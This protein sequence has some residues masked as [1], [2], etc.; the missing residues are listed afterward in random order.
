MRGQGV[1]GA[2]T[3]V[4]LAI[5]HSLDE[6][7]VALLV[8]TAEDRANMSEEDLDWYVPILVQANREELTIP[9]RD[10]EFR[11]NVRGVSGAPDGP[12]FCDHCLLVRILL[13]DECTGF[14]Q[15]EP[16]EPRG[17]EAGIAGVFN[18]RL[19]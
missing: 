5:Y 17:L 11:G 10:W 15:N 3:P 13:V 16:K 18:Q 1:D 7:V 12:V 9:D 8:P 14:A 6:G 4:A 19:S 2:W